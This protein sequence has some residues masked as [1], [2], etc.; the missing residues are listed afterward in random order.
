DIAQTIT[1]H[2]DKAL[3]S[4]C[5]LINVITG[6]KLITAGQA[7]RR[8]AALNAEAYSFNVFLYVK[9]NDCSY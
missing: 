2:F 3:P 4:G 9:S 1:L 8:R 6:Q 5:K 7:E